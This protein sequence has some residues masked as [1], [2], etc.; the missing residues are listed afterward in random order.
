MAVVLEPVVQNVTGTGGKTWMLVIFNNDDTSYEAV[1][2]A[3]LRA[4]GCDLEEAEM[5][6]WE[7][8]HHGHAP[9]HFS[10]DPENLSDPARILESV[11][12]KTEITPEWND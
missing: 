11:G 4:T 8:H 12:V 7:A 9:V 6:T 1:I 3:L 5:E 10:T 2:G